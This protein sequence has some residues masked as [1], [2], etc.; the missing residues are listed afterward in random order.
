MTNK[1]LQLLDLSNNLIK[2]IGNH[3]FTKSRF[4]RY[5][6]LEMNPLNET[7]LTRDIMHGLVEIKFVY[8]GGSWQSD[9][10]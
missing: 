4:L 3:T 9:T 7:L 8:L 10:N 5:L 1:Q 6:F 2:S